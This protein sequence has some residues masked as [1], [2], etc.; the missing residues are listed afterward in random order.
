MI[1]P[2]YLYGNDVLR[3]KSQNIDLGTDLSNIINDMFDTMN[4]AFGCGLAAPQ[5]GQNINLFITEIPDDSCEFLIKK[6]FINPVFEI[7]DKNSL[8]SMDEGC[9]SLPNITVPVKRFSKI[10]AS[11]FDE[12]WIKKEEVLNDFQSRVFLH[13]YDH[14]IGKMIIDYLDERKVKDLSKELENIEKKNFKKNNILYK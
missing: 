7:L 14:L 11:Y 13:E 3:K 9:L 2:I 12:N 6:I 5:I 8:N 10:R 4:N 1:L